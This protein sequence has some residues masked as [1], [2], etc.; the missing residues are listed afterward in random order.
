MMSAPRGWSVGAW[1]I[2]A[3]GGDAYGINA[4]VGISGLVS[5]GKS[6]VYSTLSPYGKTAADA[7]TFAVQQLAAGNPEIAAVTTIGAVLGATSYYVAKALDASAGLAAASSA[8]QAASNL[9]AALP[10]LQVVLGQVIQASAFINARSEVALQQRQAA[11]DKSYYQSINGETGTGPSSRNL[12]SADLFMGETRNPFGA[13]RGDVFDLP[14]QLNLN[15]PVLETNRSALAELLLELEEGEPQGNLFVVQK[16]VAKL[17]FKDRGVTG[18]TDEERGLLRQLRKG[19]SALYNNGLTHNAW[20]PGLVSDGGAALWVPYIDLINAAW[21]QGRLNYDY[22]VWRM[23]RRADSYG[24]SDSG[25]AHRYAQGIVAKAKDPTK[26]VLD[27]LAPDDATPSNKI[28]TA[29]CWLFAH[30]GGAKRL[31]LMVDGWELFIHPGYILPDGPIAADNPW[32]GPGSNPWYI[33]GLTPNQ[34]DGGAL[35]LALAALG[36]GAYAMLRP[37]Q[38]RALAASL[39]RRAVQAAGG[40]SR[41]AGRIASDAGRGARK[42]IGGGG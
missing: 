21:R 40:A 33:P 37:T 30:Q 2:G 15:T 27:Y 10:V 1:R 24:G 17:A 7:G 3:S 22:L 12:V 20:T 18:L 19:I 9:S 8:A 23:L 41:A 5:L 29:N 26:Y 4:G 36:V 13:A 16:N 31:K 6:Q 11:C 34:Q 35:L 39:Q 32:H 25:Q 14:K 28:Y 38:A 42:L